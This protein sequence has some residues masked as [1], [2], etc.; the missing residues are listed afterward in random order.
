MFPGLCQIMLLN[1]VLFVIFTKIV[2]VQ[3]FDSDGDG[4]LSSAQLG[5]M[6]QA[7]LCAV[8]TFTEQGCALERETRQRLEHQVCFGMYIRHIYSC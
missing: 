2:H 5:A 4:H 7:V 3:L 8:D 1:I 6:L